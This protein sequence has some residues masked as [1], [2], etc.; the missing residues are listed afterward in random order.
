M[1]NTF[2]KITYGDLF[3]FKECLCTFIN[4]HQVNCE[5]LTVM[6]QNWMEHEDDTLISILSRGMTALEPQT[7]ILKD[8]D[9]NESA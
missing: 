2:R 6:S 4:W 9:K 1:S 8:A 7:D 5:K 3:V